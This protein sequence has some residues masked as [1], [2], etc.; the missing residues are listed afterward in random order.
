MVSGA[1]AQVQPEPLTA[2]NANA[3]DTVTVERP[4]KPD[5]L[6]EKF[7]LRSFRVGTDLI[8]L[9]KTVVMK[10]QASNYFS[11]LEVNGDADFGKYYFAVDVGTSARAYDLHYGDSGNYSNSGNY[12]RIGIDINLLKKDPDRNMFFFGLRFGHASYHESANLIT[13][14]HYF[15]AVTKNLTN[16]SVTATW[17]ELVTGL[18]VKVWK[19]F[20]MGY[21][22]RM[23]FLPGVSGDTAFKSFDIPG[24]GRNGEGFYWGFN[25]QIFW[26]IPVAKQ[27]RPV[28][29]S[30]K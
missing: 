27:K 12:Y 22:A 24:Y 15:G 16:N 26:R 14:N 23:K 17:G 8:S 30:A 13:V 18:R 19:E 28:R 25:Y 11:G 10:D 2:G 20:W 4:K 7:Y 6:K 3:N 21:T 9:G 1:L 29:F 5:S